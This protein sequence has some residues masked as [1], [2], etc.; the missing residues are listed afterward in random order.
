MVKKVLGYVELEWT[1]PQCGTRNPGTHKQCSSCGKAQP[2]RV[3]FHQAAEE[4]LISDKAEIA[5]AKSGPDVHCAFCGARNPAGAERCTQC[6]ADLASADARESGGVLGAHR[7][8]LAAPVRCPSC[9]AENDAT[10]I[11]C[12]QCNARLPKAAPDKPR[13]AAPARPAKARA[14]EAAPKSTAARKT[15]RPPTRPRSAAP[16]T[17]SIPAPAMERSCRTASIGCTTSGARMAPRNGKRQRR[18]R[19]TAPI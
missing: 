18:S 7:R 19:R 4:E 17:R 15:V 10:A 5:R 9:G 16:P 12:A 2:K 11:K 6:G 8:G 13:P 1:C 14:S 3:A